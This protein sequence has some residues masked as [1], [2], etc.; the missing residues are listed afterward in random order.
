LND[1]DDDDDDDDET[2]A[3]KTIYRQQHYA[4]L[5]ISSVFIT[6]IQRL[7]THNITTWVGFE[8]GDGLEL[9]SS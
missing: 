7:M 2:K 3:T 9:K 1:D 5:F 8:L 4:Q 6:A